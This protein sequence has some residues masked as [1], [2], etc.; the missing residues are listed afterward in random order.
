MNLPLF[1]CTVDVYAPAT[2]SRFL[3]E[4][5]WRDVIEMLDIS[6][7]LIPTAYLRV[8]VALGVMDLQ[9]DI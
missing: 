3:H 7:F 1:N 5:E 9:S 6:R 8:T 2:V 4:S